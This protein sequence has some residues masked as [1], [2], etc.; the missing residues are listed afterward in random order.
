[1]ETTYTRRARY[2]LFGCRSTAIPSFPT[3][4]CGCLL[5]HAIRIPN[6][7]LRG[8][9]LPG[10]CSV[11]LVAVSGLCA[12]PREANMHT[13]TRVAVRLTCVGAHVHVPAGSTIS[14]ARGGGNSKHEHGSGGAE[15]CI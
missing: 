9:R 13:Y 5:A 15:P 14:S 1:M 12:H 7:S 11:S 2:L 4:G 6:S 8:S 3:W 10:S